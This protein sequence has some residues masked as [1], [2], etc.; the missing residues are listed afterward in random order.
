MAETEQAALAAIRDCWITGGPAFERAPEVWRTAIGDAEAEEQERCLLAILG[1]AYQVGHRPA[2]PAGL[3]V[4]PLL[5]VLALPILPDGIRPHF[6][7]AL[8]QAGGSA[9]QAR[10]LVLLA[11]RG[12]VAHPFDWMPKSSDLDLPLVYAPWIDW[13][14]GGDPGTSRGTRA[15]TLETW[16]SF[17]PATRRALL[18]ELRR[19][20][21]DAARSLIEAKAHIVPAEERTALVLVLQQALSEADAPLLKSLLTDRSGKVRD[22]AARLLARLGHTIAPE[23]GG[24]DP[25]AFMDFVSVH[26]GGI[27]A[28]GTEIIP[29]KPKS[30][31]RA[32]ERQ[33]L[34]MQHSL[35][36]FCNVLELEPHELIAGWRFAEQRAADELLAAMV[37]C[38]GSD[39]AIARLVDAVLARSDDLPLFLRLLAPQL[40]DGQVRALVLKT[41]DGDLAAL[42][43]FAA[44]ET[45]AVGWLDAPALLGSAAFGALATAITEANENQRDTVARALMAAGLLASADAAQAAI[46]ASVA[47]G[48]PPSDPALGILRLNAALN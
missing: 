40:S 3:T 11:G 26:S 43:Q 31:S 47:A 37:L 17:Y 45:Q 32:R 30:A 41:L 8:R 28:R 48:L 22:Q 18:T 46:D 12:F 19:F 29:T 4:R 44:C 16:E 39:Q 27:P 1:Q 34:F 42:A 25:Q 14:A 35:G 10:V 15:L 38:S 6:R 36:T 9:D 24:T 23:Q 7:S 33:E 21:P 13:M 5:P 20:D 2:V